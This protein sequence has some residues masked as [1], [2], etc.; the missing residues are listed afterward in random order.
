[1]GNRSCLGKCNKT[2]EHG[3][4]GLFDF[5]TLVLQQCH[6]FD[7]CRKMSNQSFFW[8]LPRSQR[9]LYRN[10]SNTITSIYVLIILLIFITFSLGPI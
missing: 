8:D 10:P 1:M 7:S 4:S 9:Y 5:R 3:L 6:R 2:K